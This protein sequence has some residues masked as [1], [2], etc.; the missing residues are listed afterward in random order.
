VFAANGQVYF[1]CLEAV[2]SE[3]VITGMAL[4]SDFAMLHS[5]ELIKTRPDQSRMWT[6]YRGAVESYTMRELSNKGGIIAAF[7]GWLNTIH[8]GRFIEGI[9]KPLFPIALL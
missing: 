8:S 1:S 7:S 4:Y 2:F 9:S 3:E 6:R 5:A